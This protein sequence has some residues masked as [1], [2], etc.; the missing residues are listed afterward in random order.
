[1]TSALFKTPKFY[2][3]FSGQSIEMTN[4]SFDEIKEGDFFFGNSFISDCDVLVLQRWL[5]QTFYSF[6]FE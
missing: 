2:A 6:L 5:F 4:K 1:M 3:L